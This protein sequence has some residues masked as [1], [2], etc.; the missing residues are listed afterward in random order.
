MPAP[1]AIHAAAI[2]HHGM[3]SPRVEV[4]RSPAD[5][6]PPIVGYDENPKHRGETTVD[7]VDLDLGAQLMKR[8]VQVARDLL[9]RIHHL[10]FEANRGPAPA[11]LARERL[12]PRRQEL[13][14]SHVTLSRPARSTAPCYT[15]PLWHA[16]RSV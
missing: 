3:P 8:H 5:Q 6:P 14:D 9:E 7:P 2:G 4:K 15:G 16:K 12:Q 10:R 13:C 11:D 1:H